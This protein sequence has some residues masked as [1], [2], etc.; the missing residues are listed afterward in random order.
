[1]FYCLMFYPVIINNRVVI[2][3]A[4]K[5]EISRDPGEI[6]LYLNRLVLCHCSVSYFIWEML[7]CLSRCRFCLCWE[8]NAAGEI[9]KS[10]HLP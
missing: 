4:T 6:V 9:I 8:M 3:K 2:T 7:Q 1:M 10:F 5:R